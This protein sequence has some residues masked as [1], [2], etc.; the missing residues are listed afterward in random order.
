MSWVTNVLLLFSLD[1]FFD[2]E[3]EEIEKPISLTNVNTWLEENGWGTLDNLDRH[4][5]CGGKA[6]QA[7]VYGGAFNFFKTDEFIKVVKAQAWRKS[8]SVQLLI[9]DENDE[10]FKLYSLSNAT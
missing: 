7:C 9:K 8:K 1:E 3:D 6:M 2:D 10:H 4:V 5:E